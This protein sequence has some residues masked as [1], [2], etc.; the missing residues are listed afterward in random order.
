MKKVKLHGEIYWAK[1]VFEAGE[2]QR[3]FREEHNSV[4]GGHAGV[5]K[6]LDKVREKYYWPGLCREIEEW[7]SIFSVTHIKGLRTLE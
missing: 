7:V 4:I 3:V 5:S 2:R 6:T 1:V